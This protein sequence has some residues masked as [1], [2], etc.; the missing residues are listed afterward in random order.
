MPKTTFLSPDPTAQQYQREVEPLCKL[1]EVYSKR[2]QQTEDGGDFVKANRINS[3]SRWKTVKFFALP[4]GKALRQVF[5]M[6]QWTDLLTLLFQRPFQR[7]FQIAFLMDKFD[8]L[9]RQWYI[10]VEF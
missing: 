5:S 7:P 2:G 8:G 9:G 10:L 3:P 4:P 1:G 6:D